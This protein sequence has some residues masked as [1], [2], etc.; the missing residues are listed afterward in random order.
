MKINLLASIAFLTFMLPPVRATEVDVE[1]QKRL[2][3]G[4]TLLKEMSL[5]PE[6]AVFGSVVSPAPLI[7]LVRQTHTARAATAVSQESLDRVGRLFSHGEL[8]PGKDVQAARAQVALDQAVAQGLEDRLVLEWG[9]WFSRK[10]AVERDKLID[11]LLAGQQSVIRISVPRGVSSAVKPVAVRLHPFGQETSVIRSEVIFPAVA[12]D[13]AYQAQCYLALTDNPA[14]PPA[15]G[16]SFSGV[17][18]LEGKPRAGLLVPH[19][20]V[21]FHLGK[22]WVYRKAGDEE[23]ERLE[24]STGEPVGGGWFISRDAI[25]PDNIVIQGAQLLLSQETLG[26]AEDE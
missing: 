5:P 21:V 24:I 16:L 22:A 26:P 12:V 4:I 25:K 6:A 20:A 1:A 8:L 10:S 13:A 3:L 7:E 15:V 11:G 14:T 23:F 18:E 2:G 9:P 17:M 19:E